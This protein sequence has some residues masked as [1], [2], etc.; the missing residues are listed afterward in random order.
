MNLWSRWKATLAHTEPAHGLAVLRMGM[1]L[2]LVI[3]MLSVW[4][5]DLVP[6]LWLT[7]EDG[8]YLTSQQSGSFLVN[9][10][11]GRTTTLIW[12]LWATSLVAGLSLLAGVFPRVAAFIGMEAFFAITWVNPHAGGSYDMLISNL[13]LLLVFAQSGATGSVVAKWKTGRWWPD[14]PVPAWPRYLVIGQMV[15]MYTSTGF[16]KVSASWVPGGDLSALFYILQQPSWQ[17]FDM[18]WAAQVY[19]LTQAATLGTWL[20][21]VGAPIL[22]VA[23]WFRRTHDKP[24]RVRAW[25]NRWDIRSIWL[26]IGVAMHV[27]IMLLMEVGTFSV[28]C[29]FSYAC[30]F[31]ADEFKW[32]AQKLSNRIAQQ[33]PNPT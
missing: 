32:A 17:R 11:G 16:Q 26:A 24:G 1:G 10:L 22:L 21:E 31:H 3:E 18:T 33:T 12:G 5:A 15:T 29:V 27:G 4:S 19:P 14:T 9:A 2:V 28:V 6:M 7:P 25:F 13:L 20:F 23:F 8:G 30:F